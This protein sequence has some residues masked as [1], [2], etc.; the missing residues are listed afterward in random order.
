MVPIDVWHYKDTGTTDDGGK[1]IKALF[2]FEA[3]TNPK[4]PSLIRRAIALSPIEPDKRIIMDFLAGSASTAEAVLQEN[5]E[6]EVCSK[7]VLVE[8]GEHFDTV[9]LPR[10]C[11]VAYA[12]NWRDGK[13]RSRDEGLSHLAKYIRLESYEDALNN[14]ETRRTAMQQSLLDARE[15]QGA[16]GLKEQYL[17]RYMLD[18]ETRSSQSLLNV[19]AF[20]D[21]TAYNLKVKQ[22]GSDESREVNVD[23]LETFNYLIGLTVQHI[24]AP[25]TFA[26]EF[27]RDSENRLRLK[28]RL[29]PDAAG[30]WWFRT[31]AGSTPDGR[32]TLVIWRKLTG[33]PEQNN[34]V[35]DEWFTRQ[36]YSTK[37]Y[38]FQLI[39][40]NGDNNLENLKAPDDTWKVRLIEEDFHRLIFDME[41]V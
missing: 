28:G 29:K 17:L 41:G 23:L 19:Q 14:L 7:Y 8:I 22:P 2:G 24:A 20:S 4:P 5:R 30:P 26:A 37:D 38:E 3:F 10:I 25:Q 18:V 6:A 11:K 21:P 33:D 31:V 15:T 34:L 16:N 27:E 39:Y 13:P 12:A 9:M 40:V 1:A 36:D 35:L 32:R